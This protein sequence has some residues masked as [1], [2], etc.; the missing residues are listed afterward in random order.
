MGSYN[1]KSIMRKAIK[2]RAFSKAAQKKVINN[3][4]RAKRVML[5]EFDSHPVTK[6]ISQGSKGINLTKTLGGYGNLFSFIGFNEN[7]NPVEKVRNFLGYWPRIKGKRVSGNKHYYIISIPDVA[8]FGVVAS[9]PWEMGRSWVEGVETGISGF[10]YYM[11][12]VFGKDIKSRSGSAIQIDNRIRSEHYRPT[13][14]LAPII[15]KLVIAILAGY[16]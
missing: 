8:D 15:K 6:E 1:R 13:P 7:S 12:N 5:E 2:T 4:R 9:M 3:L 14:Y 16:K 11:A 10:G